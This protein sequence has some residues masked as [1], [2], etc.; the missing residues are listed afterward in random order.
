MC[1]DFGDPDGC[2]D[3]EGE[4]L[5]LGSSL[6]ASLDGAEGEVRLVFSCE[7]TGT[8]T[9][10]IEGTPAASVPAFQVAVRG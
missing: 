4:M 9:E 1:F 10:S 5:A 2:E 7:R 6:L 3:A 8:I